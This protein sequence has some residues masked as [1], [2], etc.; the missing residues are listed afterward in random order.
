MHSKP[1]IEIWR[2][3]YL[4]IYCVVW[5]TSGDWRPPKS[6]NFHPP[7]LDT[8]Y[9]LSTPIAFLGVSG[10]PI[11]EYGEVSSFVWQPLFLAT[12][13][14]G[15]VVSTFEWR[16]TTPCFA[17]WWNTEA[18]FLALLAIKSLAGWGNKQTNNVS[19]CSL[20]IHVLFTRH[21]NTRSPNHVVSQHSEE[22]VIFKSWV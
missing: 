7:A 1:N 14:Y 18:Q 20:K 19:Q 13:S 21:K 17:P 15:T 8:P 12:C 3:I 16:W 5:L 11:C 10:E 6:I 4:F 22:A 9:I 2:F